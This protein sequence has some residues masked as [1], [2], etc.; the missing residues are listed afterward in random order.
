MK[1]GI[2]VAGGNCFIG[3]LLTESLVAG[4]SDVVVL[5]RTPRT[6]GQSIRQ[7]GWVECT[8]GEWARE[9]DGARTLSVPL[10]SLLV[11]HYKVRQSTAIVPPLFQ[12]LEHSWLLS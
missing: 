1:N 10:W 4:N 3:S 6:T 7:V 8:L 5:T 12:I 11:D 9:L 2:V